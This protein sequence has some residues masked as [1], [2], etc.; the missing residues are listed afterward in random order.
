MTIFGEVLGGSY[1]HPDVK[2]A[3]NA[4]K[5]QKGIF[6]SPRNEY[7]AF[8]IQINHETYLDVNEAN[9]LF[10]KSGMLYAKTLE[11][12][13]IEKCLEYPN[14][15]Q[16]TIPSELGLPAL[17]NNNCEGVI[18]KPK[19]NSHFRNGSRVILK[20][21]NDKWLEKIKRDKKIDKSKPLPEKVI[22]LQEAI[23]DYITENRLN[24]V[25]SKIGEVTKNDFGKIIADLNRDAIEDFTKDFR[26]DLEALDKKEKKLV[27]K[28]IVHKSSKLIREFFIKQTREESVT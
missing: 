21:K 8:D 22:S 24:N 12:G 26:E 16:T 7:Y 2:P 18:I 20:N 1:P 9:A 11:E 10:E 5:V 25:L 4:L 13:T 3:K 17:E 19:T 27:T 15:F 28:S 23:K 6:Y 14:K